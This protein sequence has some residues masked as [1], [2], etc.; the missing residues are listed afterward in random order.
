MDRCCLFASDLAGNCD[1]A[2]SSGSNV[3][4][5]AAIHEGGGC[6]DVLGHEYRSPGVGNVTH[7]ENDL[8]IREYQEIN[9]HLRTNTTQFVNWFSLL[10]TFSLVT[11]M[12][13]LVTNVHR[14]G[15]R[16][17][18]LE[19]GVPIVCL[20]LHVL[21]FAGILIFRH[22]IIAAHSKIDEIIS[23]LGDKG[24]S[25]VPVRFS[26]WMTHLMAAGFVVSYFTWLSLL[27]FP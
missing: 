17:I 16:G 5:T 10:L 20:I 2:A 6:G 3:S 23:L 27:V 25:P 24:G 14:S 1:L 15:L 8:L 18:A 19:Y 12:A 13:L 21:V 11:A 22:Y 7:S 9:A 4:D 26:L